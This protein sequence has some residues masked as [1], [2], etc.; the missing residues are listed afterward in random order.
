MF[1]KVKSWATGVFKKAKSA[2]VGIAV[3]VATVASVPAHAAVDLSAVTGAF[4]SA[5]IVTGVLAI[6]GTLAVVHVSVKGVKI[7]LSM[8]K[9]G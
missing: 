7:V 4:T 9:T 2:V 6:A 8:L 3:G 1:K 5:D